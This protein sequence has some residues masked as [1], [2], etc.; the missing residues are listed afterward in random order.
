MQ[1]REIRNLFGFKSSQQGLGARI[2]L[3]T[4]DAVT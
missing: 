4:I 1:Q 3:F 2:T